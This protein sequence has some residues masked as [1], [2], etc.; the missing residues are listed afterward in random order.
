MCACMAATTSSYS[1]A[2]VH[3]HWQGRSGTVHTPVGQESI[4]L[5]SG[6][7]PPPPRVALA[8][9]R[10]PVTWLTAAGE[11]KGVLT[12]LHCFLQTQSF[13]LQ[14]YSCVGLSGVLL[15]CMGILVGQ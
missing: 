2:V 11:G 12:Y 7:T 3:S 8:A 5:Q 10:G 1:H 15:C 14:V 4:H 9:G 6:L 13:H